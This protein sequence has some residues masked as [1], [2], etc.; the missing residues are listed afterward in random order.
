MGRNT[1][2]RNFS[3]CISPAIPISSLSCDYNIFRG[4]VG[5]VGGGRTGGI[6][7]LQCNVPEADCTYIQNVRRSEIWCC[8]EMLEVWFV[9]SPGYGQPPT[10][11]CQAGSQRQAEALRAGKS[12]QHFLLRTS[13]QSRE[14][15]KA[16]HRVIHFWH[17][18]SQP[19]AQIKVTRHYRFLHG[20]ARR[21]WLHS[22]F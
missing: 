22:L 10:E 6:K 12:F 7:K 4:G 14:E 15:H 9:W 11:Q 16:L 19:A 8:W 2:L 21:N 5:W 1:L 3:H 17:F 13:L 18:R 20:Q